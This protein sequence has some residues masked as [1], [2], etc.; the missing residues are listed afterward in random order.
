M[1][2]NLR[3]IPR[4]Q[5]ARDTWCYSAGVVHA[6]SERKI[7]VDGFSFLLHL[8]RWQVQQLG[9]WRVLVH[10]VHSQLQLPYI[11]HRQHFLHLQRRL[12][13][14][15]GYHM[16]GMVSPILLKLARFLTRAYAELKAILLD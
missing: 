11:Q 14:I 15:R 16:R 13:R 4:W 8:L 9:L 12:L 1:E 7:L 2:L 3:W 10:S 5:G 6:V